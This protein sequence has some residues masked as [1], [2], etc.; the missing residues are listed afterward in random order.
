MKENQDNINMR[1]KILS[2]LFFITFLLQVSCNIGDP[3]F[4]LP[5]HF[6]ALEGNLDNIKKIL[7]DGI[8]I[9]AENYGGRTALHIAAFEGHTDVVL[10]LVQNGANVNARSKG[11]TTPLHL[12]NNV[13]IA[14]ILLKNGAEINAKDNSNQTALRRAIRN[15]N[16]SN[17]ALFLIKEG[18][19]IH[20]KDDNGWNPLLASVHAGKIEV[21]KILFEK[22]ADLNV[23]NEYNQT[24]LSIAKE[25]NYEELIKL[26]ETYSKKD[27]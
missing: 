17:L 16:D 4:G 14:E 3:T 24:P 6:M 27:E 13:E 1:K 9:D 26:F 15:H 18:I 12:A 22:G 2:L 8:D 10:F 5:I 21:A 19:Y 7:K 23:K 25:R 11:K 20:S